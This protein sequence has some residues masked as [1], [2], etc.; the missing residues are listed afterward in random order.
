MSPKKSHYYAAMAFSGGGAQGRADCLTEFI[1]NSGQ[2]NLRN[3]AIWWP[4]YLRPTYTT[5][6]VSTKPKLRTR[7]VKYTQ[8]ATNSGITGMAVQQP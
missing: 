4:R 2:P 8:Y 6:S 1:K 5:G 3:T 7:I